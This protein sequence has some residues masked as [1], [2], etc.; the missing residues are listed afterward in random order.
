AGTFML[1]R[2]R[3]LLAGAHPPAPA[4]DV[5]GSVRFRIRRADRWCAVH[6]KCLLY[7]AR[8]PETV[9]RYLTGIFSVPV[10][11]T[12]QDAGLVIGDRRRGAP[13]RITEDGLVVL[14]QALDRAGVTYY[15][16]AKTYD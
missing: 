4:L 15:L 12:L 5:P 9:W 13:Q 8:S 11:E 1:R 7:L 6:L 10:V 2:V 3:A 16:Q 14:R